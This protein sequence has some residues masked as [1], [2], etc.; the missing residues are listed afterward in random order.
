MVMIPEYNLLN[1]D[2]K[3]KNP[4]KMSVDFC[5]DIH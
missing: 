3:Q 4:A 2:F 5:K 1:K